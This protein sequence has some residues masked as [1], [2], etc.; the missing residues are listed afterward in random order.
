MD[1]T[2]VFANFYSPRWGHT[3]CYSFVFSMNSLT[4]THHA[5]KCSA[6]WEDNADPTWRGESFV[7]TLKNDSIYPPDGLEG[8]IEFLWKEWRD[9]QLNDEQ[10]QVEL[11]ALV[12]YINVSTKA[13]PR[14]EF[15]QKIF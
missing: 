8:L 13:H 10:L 9:G 7:G 14:T 6:T 1:S 15:W 2:E 4:I 12:E 3:D 11:H 5:R